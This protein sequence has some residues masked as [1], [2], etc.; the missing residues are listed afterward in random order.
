MSIPSTSG[1]HKDFEWGTATSEYQISGADHCPDSDWAWYENNPQV[2]ETRRGTPLEKSSNGIDHWNHLDRDVSFLKQLGVTSYRFSIEW[3]KV[4][5]R[6]GQ[7][8][9]DAIDH[10]KS[11]CDKLNQNGIKPMITLHHFTNPQWFAAQDGFEREENIQ[12]FVSFC[13][14]VFRQ[15]GDKTDLW[16]TINEPGV[17]AFMGYLLGKHPPFRANVHM[18][19]VVLSNLLKA[20]CLAY[21]SLKAIRPE[22]QIGIVHS[23]LKF[24]TFTSWNPLEKAVAG[25]LTYIANDLVMNFFRNRR[26]EL[27]MP[28]RVTPFLANVTIAVPTKFSAEKLT[29]WFGINYYSRPLLKAG[30]TWP[31]IESTCREGEQMTGYE[32][33]F[34]PEGIEEAIDDVKQIGVPMYI[35]ETGTPDSDK[36]DR[37]ASFARRIITSIGR[38]IDKGADIRGM[39]WWSMVDNWEW[40]EGYNQHIK[41]GL[42]RY[43]KASNS[44]EIKQGAEAYLQAIKAHK[45]RV[46]ED[47]EVL[48]G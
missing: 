31:P 14:H 20:H 42:A 26:A 30:F 18:T 33:R 17:Y 19:G 1:F 45:A 29:D 5:P 25:N 32:Y 23:V 8:N 43:L 3:S 12:S 37:L 27:K 44:F 39:Y 9:Q 11:L 2:T 34:D 21:Q 10:Y 35:T 15:L 40:A 38:S 6:K 48:A 13:E 28:N 41:F 24:K 7:Y 16:V 47:D 4:E 36:P 46:N 22:A